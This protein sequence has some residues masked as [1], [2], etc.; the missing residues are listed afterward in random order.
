M[1]TCHSDQEKGTGDGVLGNS[2]VR[3]RLD[4]RSGGLH[5]GVG[6]LPV[7]PRRC[8]CT[9]MHAT[10]HRMVRRDR[11][12]RFTGGTNH[13]SSSCTEHRRCAATPKWRGC[14]T[15]HA[16]EIDTRVRVTNGWP[17]DVHAYVDV[18]SVNWAGLPVENSLDDVPRL[19]VLFALHCR[20][21][22]VRPWVGLW[23]PCRRPSFRAGPA[24]RK[25]FRPP[26]RDAADAVSVPV[27]QSPRKSSRAAA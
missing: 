21:R 8:L 3:L 11:R 13:A 26:V 7:G 9:R 23:L 12:V 2:F 18:R 19:L 10:P 24:S 20:T 16:D 27:A 25:T 17:D 15:I 14:C 5:S 6:G 4:R 22:G 1:E